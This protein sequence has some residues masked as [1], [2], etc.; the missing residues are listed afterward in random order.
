[1]EPV[2]DLTIK[3][4]TEAQRFEAELD[5]ERAVTDYYL[6]N[7]IIIL[8]HTEVSPALEGRG[9]AR[10]L[11]QT[12]LDEAREKGYQV[13]P[14]CPYVAGFI[15]KHPEYQDLVMARFKYMVI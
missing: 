5:G 13:M 6:N 4:N 7:N 10:K 15:R 8:R 2:Q 12:A 3:N 14:L 11:V 1:M 9:V